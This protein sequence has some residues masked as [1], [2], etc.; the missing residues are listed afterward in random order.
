MVW[1]GVV[2]FARNPAVFVF[3]GLPVSLQHHP[4]PQLCYFILFYLVARVTTVAACSV[5]RTVHLFCFSYPFP[6]RVPNSADLL[7]DFQ[8]F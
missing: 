4:P 6:G 8:S 7:Q 2:S 5:Q 3:D 1:R